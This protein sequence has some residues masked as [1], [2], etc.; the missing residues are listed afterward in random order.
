MHPPFSTHSRSASSRS[1]A[2]PRPAPAARPLARAPWPAAGLP[3]VLVLVGACASRSAAPE[4][5]PAPRSDGARAAAGTDVAQAAA[6]KP[7]VLAP[8]NP[9]A[10]SY[11]PEEWSGPLL[12]LEA[13]PHGAKVATGDVLLRFDL[14]GL[15]ERIRDAER[16][17][18]S[19]EVRHAGLVARQKLEEEAASSS[20]AQAR[21]ALTRSQ[22]ALAAWKEHDLAFDRRDDELARRRERSYVEDQE[23]ELTQLEEMYK[24]DELVS[25]TEELVLKRQRRALGI[26]VDA[27]ALARERAKKRLDI[28][29]QLEREQREESVRAQG[30]AVERQARA[31]EIDRAARADAL[32]RSADEL[33]D[34]EAR[35]ARLR[36]DRAAL[37]ATSGRDGVF[38]HGAPR[39]WRPGRA[40]VRIERGAT[41]AA[42]AEVAAVA[43]PAVGSAR[44]ELGGA[45]LARW[46]D[47][48]RALVRPQ[49]G[50]PLA[51]TLRVE[52]WPRP[53]GLFDAF[54]ELSAPA[55]LPAGTRADVELSP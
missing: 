13:L 29:Q 45:D 36:R 54:V 16:D 3:L 49:G 6:T 46:K 51:G 15:E 34:K 52:P 43:D 24:R 26:A 7:A 21:A 41:L 1:T 5:G 33:A 35:L 50:A 53:D 2:G 10:W 37:S 55:L 12:V 38:L 8:A 32:A 18:K 20:L 4:A 17:S 25:G 47:G 14:R 11:W 30:E 44:L 22:R 42:Q 27:T 28:D 40:P 9:A 31:L 48:A 23:D 39:D 19:A